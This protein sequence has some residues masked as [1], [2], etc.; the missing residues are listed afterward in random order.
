MQMCVFLTAAVQ[1]TLQ[2]CLSAC[3][4]GTT[5]LFSIHTGSLWQPI[6]KLILSHAL[7]SGPLRDGMSVSHM[8]ACTC[9][10]GNAASL[11]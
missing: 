9:Q 5:G 2:L 3:F 8:D 11:F 10:I 1:H 4:R 6:V 7:S